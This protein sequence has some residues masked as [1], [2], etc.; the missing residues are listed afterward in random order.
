ML[1]QLGVEHV[2]ILNILLWHL[3]K[4][5]CPGL[6]LFFGAWSQIDFESRSGDV[7]FLACWWEEDEIPFFLV[8][9]EGIN[10]E[11]IPELGH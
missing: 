8:L 2:P 10:S 1:F 5:G 6:L 11:K 7:D 9:G 4:L 3:W